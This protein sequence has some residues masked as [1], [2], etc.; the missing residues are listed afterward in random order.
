MA[1]FKF[2]LLESIGEA[3]VESIRKQMLKIGLE[4][5]NNIY[6]TID[7]KI[8]SKTGVLTFVIAEYYKNIEEGADAGANRGVNIPIDVMVKWVKKKRIATGALAVRIANAIRAAIF[9]RG[10][11][12]PIRPRP[13]VDEGIENS[14]ID[15]TFALAMQEFL[16]D[17]I[18]NAIKR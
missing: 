8:N 7:Y 14:G 16:D 5:F 11:R 15:L 13:F 3:V 18:L 10:I 4:K 12:F 1:D 6:K 9:R 17:K 2:R